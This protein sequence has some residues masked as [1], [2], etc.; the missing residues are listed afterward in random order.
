MAIEKAESILKQVKEDVY[1]AEASKIAKLLINSPFLKTPDEQAKCFVRVVNY[2]QGEQRASFVS[3]KIQFMHRGV[4]DN[5]KKKDFETA[6]VWL[7]ACEGI[8]KL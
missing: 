3:Q 7:E 2:M 1:K 4:V 5:L 8:N 6:R